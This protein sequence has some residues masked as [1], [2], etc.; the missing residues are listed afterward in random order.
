[1][2]SSSKNKNSPI[3]YKYQSLGYCHTVYNLISRR[4][5]ILAENPPQACDSSSSLDNDKSTKVIFNSQVDQCQVN[6]GRPCRR[7]SHQVH[8]RISIYVG[9]QTG[10]ADDYTT[11]IV[12]HLVEFW[13][14]PASH[15]ERIDMI[16]ADPFA[17]RDCEELSI[18][19]VAT[20]G[21][22]EPPENSKTFW[23]G[24]TDATTSD[25]WTNCPL[26]VVGLGHSAFPLFC[27]FGKDLFAKLVS[28]GAC[29]LAGLIE[30]DGLNGLDEDRLISHVTR[31]L[32][33][34]LGADNLTT[35]R[36]A[37]VKR[38]DE[39][40]FSLVDNYVN[41]TSTI[42]KAA[43]SDSFVIESATLLTDR[44]AGSKTSE[45]CNY[46]VVVS[47][48]GS[49][50][51]ANVSKLYGGG[52]VGFYPPIVD[53]E[54]DLLLAAFYWEASD[55][56]KLTGTEL[57]CKFIHSNASSILGRSI[58]DGI[59]VRDL[60]K[61]F[62]DFECTEARLNFY[63]D[64]LPVDHPEMIKIRK[65]GDSWLAKIVDTCVSV[66]DFIISARGTYEFLI[67]LEKAFLLPRVK[68]RQYSIASS[69]HNSAANSHSTERLT[70]KLIVSRAF[71]PR[72]SECS[73]CREGKI[74]VGRMTGVLDRL[75]QAGSKT[76]TP[77]WGCG[78]DSQ[79]RP[80]Y[81]R[82]PG[83]WVA[84]GSGIAP[85]L[86]FIHQRKENQYRSDRPTVLV[87]GCKT[88]SVSDFLGRQ[89]I[90]EAVKNNMLDEVILSFS[91]DTDPAM[92]V[93]RI[94]QQSGC[95]DPV[96][97]IGGRQMYVG[98]VIKEVGSRMPVLR[99]VL[100]SAREGSGLVIL[101]GSLRMCGPVLQ[102][103]TDLLALPKHISQVLDSEHLILEL[104]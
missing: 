77:I 24:L 1:M 83:V 87:Y 58:P 47:V 27:Q 80:N 100:E 82:S 97:G 102:A 20:Y 22:G 13:K 25:A 37:T 51:A 32:G 69:P 21:N 15:I 98:D 66:R 81:W 50:V 23:Q 9:T 4:F 19:V 28:L 8:K 7:E 46:E 17:K 78:S 12:T 68:L 52:V 74:L 33:E 99:H 62:I 34:Y 65:D 95:L 38:S 88:S 6:I 63:Q 59:S 103:M 16:D 48:D 44:P 26:L 84:T 93:V 35:D 86:G 29:P 40:L 60:F 53:A 3:A 61:F 85:F 10:T 43:V 89:E 67:P 14:F 64:I 49:D 18:F 42:R 91:R 31:P 94:N 104:W 45:A 57:G 90:I 11:C 101:C 30:M 75:A 76:P 70:F 39:Q 56:K 72:T 55:G 5:G 96:S 79:I 2:R 54:V 41:I 92:K 73:F 71:A 36:K